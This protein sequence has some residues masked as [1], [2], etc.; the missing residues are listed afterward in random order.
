MRA[1]AAAANQAGAGFPVAVQ[2][3]FC[4]RQGLL[5][6]R[7]DRGL[8]L[9][10]PFVLASAWGTT[11]REKLSRL[12]GWPVAAL[13][14]D[15]INF[16]GRAAEVQWGLMI[17]VFCLSHVPALLTRQT[18]GFEGRDLLL[19]AFL[20]FVAQSSDV[21]QYVWGKLLGRQITPFSPWRAGLMALLINL[22]GFCGGL[23]MSAIK[24]D[25]GV[26]DWGRMIE[27]HGG[28]LDRLD[29]VISAAPIFFHVTRY[30]WTPW[31]GGLGRPRPAVTLPRRR[32]ARAHLGQV[33]SRQDNRACRIPARALC[34]R[35][36]SPL[37]SS[38]PP[39]RCSWRKPGSPSVWRP[40]SG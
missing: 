23:V 6:R 33:S 10:P 38:A 34:P 39:R 24:R 5:H 26:N 21:L 15:T 1:I 3:V 11:G 32:F 8:A 18:P 19:I 14:M 20:V 25:R 27:G 9:T 2:G 7:S 30:L 29:S 12:N 13:R 17:S 40:A 37:V 4:A 35:R 16:M 31:S 36:G 22:M 28:V